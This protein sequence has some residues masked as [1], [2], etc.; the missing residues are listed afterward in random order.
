MKGTN[1]GKAMP[2]TAIE[3]PVA[4]PIRRGSAAKMTN[5]GSPMVCISKKS[6]E[7]VPEPSITA[8]YN[9]TA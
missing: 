6:V 8:L 5:A 3:A 7:A 1:S 9:I 4:K 2:T